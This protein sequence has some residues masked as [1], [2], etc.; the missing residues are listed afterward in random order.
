VGA[1]LL[2]NPKV[3]IVFVRIADAYLYQGKPIT[4]TQLS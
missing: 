2:Y 1:A 3:K 4:A